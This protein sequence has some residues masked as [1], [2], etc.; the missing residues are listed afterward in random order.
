MGGGPPLPP[1]A[2]SPAGLAPSAAIASSPGAAAGSSASV[3]R[4]G[5]PGRLH[6]LPQPLEPALAAVAA[7]AVP[8]EAGGRVEHVRAVDPHRAGLHPRRDVEREVDV[9][10]PQAGG[11]TVAR[12]VGEL[13]G[14][15]RRAEGHQRDDGA[16]DLDPRHGAGRLDVGQQRGRIEPALLGAAPRRLPQR[17][18]LLLAL[19]DQRADALELHR[20][21]DGPDV[22]RL[23]ERV[24]DAERLHAGL[25]AS[26][27]AGRPRPPARGSGSRRSTP[28]P[29]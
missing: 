1:P 29:G 18:A 27:P 15:V 17:R 26:R 10:R 9:L 22:D 13:D 5:R 19:L 3:G 21:D 7:L 6:V 4:V 8:A 20:G 28:G 14:F 23:V 11:E 2:P 12:V 16:E 24:A 25:A